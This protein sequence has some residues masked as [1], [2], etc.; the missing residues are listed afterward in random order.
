MRTLTS[1]ENQRPF[2]L[3]RWFSIVSLVVT[4]GVTVIFGAALSDYFV[5]ESIRRDAMLTT[6]FIRSIAE[7]EAL[8][9]GFSGQNIA[10][11]QILD[12]RSLANLSGSADEFLAGA[13]ARARAEFFDH[14]RLMP[15]ALLA[16]VFAP[17][18]TIAWSTNPALIGQKASP[19]NR[20]F[21]RAVETGETVAG[22]HFKQSAGS[23]IEQQFVRYPQDVY[24]EN[25]VPLVDRAGRVASVVEIYKEPADLIGAIER[26]YTLIWV[27]ALASGGTIYLALRWIVIRAARQLDEQQRQLIENEYLVAVGEMASAVAHALRNPLA[28]IRTSA[29]L[30]MEARGASVTKSFEDVVTQVDRL[31][32]W[33]RE[34]LQFALPLSAEGEPVELSAAIEDVLPNFKAAMESAGIALDWSAPER[35]TAMVVANRALLGQVLNSLLS[36]AVEAMPHGGR[37]GLKIGPPSDKRVSLELRDTGCG[38]SEKQLADVF[39]PFRT[40]KPHGLGAGLPLVKRVMERFGGNVVITSKEREGTTVRLTFKVA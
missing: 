34:L 25:Y 21:W 4:G 5:V 39:R 20:D 6:Q 40:T 13:M 14:L 2:N 26:G 38:M 12:R 35:P 28:A 15:E 22:G 9:G 3:R 31:S 29:E 37:L 17:D 32:K 8:H 16:T 10:V 19:D 24:I 33:V 1:V 27:A 23:R 30:G 11:G 18:G 7:I 36:N